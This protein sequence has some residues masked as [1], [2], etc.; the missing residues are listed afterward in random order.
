MRHETDGAD[1]L[2]PF[3]LAAISLRRH[4][5]V[6]PTDQLVRETNG[7]VLKKSDAAAEAAMR[8]FLETKPQVDEERVRAEETELRLRRLCLSFRPPA[9]TFDHL[10]SNPIQVS[11]PSVPLSPTRRKRRSFG[12]RA[13]RWRKWQSGWSG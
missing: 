11:F 13:R 12:L 3:R 7:G 6:S 9:H 5:Q 8:E 4:V 1:E 2:G 10:A